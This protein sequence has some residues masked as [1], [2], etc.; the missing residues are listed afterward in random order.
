[1]IIEYII[2]QYQWTT[3]ST[4]AETPNSDCPSIRTRRRTCTV[5]ASAVTRNVTRAYPCSTTCTLDSVDTVEEDFF[6]ERCVN[7]DTGGKV[8]I[9]GRG[10]AEMHMRQGN[11]LATMLIYTQ[12]YSETL[13][14][15]FE[16]ESLLM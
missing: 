13:N 12:F 3:W 2:V 6:P 14:A 1:M 4:W 15:T 5:D 9:V 8:Q 11:Y 7:V 16:S 10:T